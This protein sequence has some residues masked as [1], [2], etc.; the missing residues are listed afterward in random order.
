[1]DDNPSIFF[2]LQRKPIPVNRLCLPNIMGGEI[3]KFRG[4]EINLSQLNS[5]VRPEIQH[6]VIG[7]CLR[8]TEQI[9]IDHVKNETVAFCQTTTDAEECC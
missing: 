8:G 5:Y 6:N 7:S 4:R 2:K 3:E 1:M 9:K